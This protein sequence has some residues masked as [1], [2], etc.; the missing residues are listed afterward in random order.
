MELPATSHQYIFEQDIS[1]AVSCRVKEAFPSGNFISIVFDSY[2]D[3][4]VRTWL[5]RIFFFLSSTSSECSEQILTSA[6][7]HPTL[8]TTMSIC[9][10]N[11]TWSLMVVFSNDR[12]DV[13]PHNL[14][15]QRE[16]AWMKFSQT[17][18]FFALQVISQ[19]SYFFFFFQWTS[20]GATI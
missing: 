4:R 8:H 18:V 11:N 16:I 9:F 10:E 15:W 19:F 20:W 12:L 5:W 17:P 1:A 13:G 7:P 14:F 2:F 6:L 3:N